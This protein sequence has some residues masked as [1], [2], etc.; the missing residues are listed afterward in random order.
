MV[1]LVAR[2]SAEEMFMI[3]SDLLN[4]TVNESDERIILDE[5]QMIIDEKLIPAIEIVRY[6]HKYTVV[7]NIKEIILELQ[8]Y[9]NHKELIN[10]N[11]VAIYNPSSKLYKKIYNK[12]IRN[13]CSKDD[14]IF[15]R[16]IRSIFKQSPQSM[17]SLDVPTFIHRLDE[18][19]G[20]YISSI[21]GNNCELDEKKYAN[22]IDFSDSKKIDL[23]N[24]LHDIS[25]YSK[26]MTNNLVISVI[27]IS[28][29]SENVLLFNSIDEL[30]IQGKD[31][32]ISLLSS[33]KNIS[34]I[35]VYNR[36][37]T[38]NREN[39][40]EY[41]KKNKI[42]IKFIADVEQEFDN[43]IINKQYTETN[44]ICY[45]YLLENLLVE[46]SWFLAK[47]N[48]CLRAPLEIIN[49]ELVFDSDEDEIKNYLNP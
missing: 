27:P 13:S 43:L 17:F 39:L 16:M 9:L 38:K 6:N 31:I 19:N 47:N 21:T 41:G 37:A 48:A 30:W 40:E 2:Q 15:E 12:Y 46:I 49:S 25:V 42:E 1:G 22:L 14:N 23:N 29:N 20:L 45:Y 10:S 3:I 5:M 24:L 44:N 4:E 26:D 28:K 32:D 11:H 36:I 34:R 18:K 33:I 7:E 8:Y 35:F